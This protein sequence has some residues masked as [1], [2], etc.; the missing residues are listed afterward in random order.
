LSEFDVIVLGIGGMGSAALYHLARRG[1]SVCGIEQHEIGNNLGSSHG[2]VRVIR[3][4]YFEHPDY[5]PL[6]R[7]AY[8]LWQSLEE[9]AGET[10]FVKSGM[11]VF[12]ASDS[13]A[14]VGLDACYAKH[15]L[16]HE[17]MP[18]PRLCERF[19]QFHVPDDA[20]GYW[21]PIA[22]YLYVEKCVEQ[23]ARLAIENGA[24]TRTGTEVL[25]WRADSKG[26][27]VV[28]SDGELFAHHLILTA[29]AW[30]GPALASVGVDLNVTR[31]IQLWYDSPT[32]TS[33][34]APQFPVFFVESECGPYYGFPSIDGMGLKVAQH[35]DGAPVEDPSS[36][37]RDLLPGE[38]TGVRQFLSE[39]FP[40]LKPEL[41]QH[42]AC[43]YSNTPDKN[44]V[45]DRHPEFSNVS[46][47]AGFSGH[48]F[49]FSCVVG[50]VLADL[51][52]IGRTDHPIAFLGLDRFRA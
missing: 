52:M 6:L 25:D 28:T 16:P 35:F 15:D 4:A 20:V 22:G 30:S 2:H 19:P 23:H 17:R 32:L 27:T 34:E 12:G 50:E 13:E 41:R 46:I 51:A 10:L 14:I 7:R 29:G 36:L 37:I 18:A 31:Q 42:D 26:V 3:Q 45:V 44:F 21:D 40:D 24:E 9:Q 8:H 33:F 47:A 11:V 5:V 1:V 39:T 43:M 38:E 48:G 49:K